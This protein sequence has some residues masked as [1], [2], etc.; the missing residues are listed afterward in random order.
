MTRDARVV[1]G[2]SFLAL[3]I[4]LLAANSSAGSAQTRTDQ[5]SRN[6]RTSLSWMYGEAL[7]HLSPARF[8]RIVEASADPYIAT[9]AKSEGRQLS[10]RRYLVTGLLIGAGVGALAGTVA[11]GAGGGCND[12]MVSPL[13]A[14]PI[15]AIGGAIVGTIVGG[16]V[17]KVR[18]RSQ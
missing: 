13:I 16:V 1:P 5:Q 14:I 7:V 10:A 11:A 9:G 6:N 4:I 12:C 2:R 15:F 17:Y 8:H 18:S 3:A